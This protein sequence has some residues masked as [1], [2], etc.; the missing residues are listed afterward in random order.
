MALGKNTQTVSVHQ[1]APN[2]ASSPPQRG[3]QAQPLPVKQRE[4]SCHLYLLEAHASH[5]LSGYEAH[6]AACLLTDCKINMASTRQES[7]QCAAN[8]NHQADH[9]FIYIYIYIQ[10]KNLTEDRT[11]INV[12][13]NLGGRHINFQVSL[14]ISK[15]IYGVWGGL[16]CWKGCFLSTMFWASWSP[17][18]NIF[19]S[20]SSSILTWKKDPTVSLVPSISF[21]LQR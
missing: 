5:C 6:M 3:T 7:G 17:A 21:A 14:H 20:L 13:K 2:Q 9:H 10:Q 4:S 8:Y 19:L 12:Q 1:E 18:G 11:P 16:L 15:G